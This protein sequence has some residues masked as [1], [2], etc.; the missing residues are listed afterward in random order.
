MSHPR[1][2]FHSMFAIM[3]MSVFLVSCGGGVETSRQYCP[4]QGVLADTE[5]LVGL[6]GDVIW[7]AQISGTVLECHWDAQD[8]RLVTGL[9]MNGNVTSTSEADFAT[10]LTLPA[11]VI[12]T[13]PSD[14]ILVKKEF[15]VEISTS[16]ELQ[17]VS[18]SKDVGSLTLTLAADDQ[19]E[20]H[21]I[22]VGF[23]LTPD[24]LRANRNYRTR[25]LG[26]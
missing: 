22:L 7:S 20:G 9:T 12:M 5:R 13:G 6:S 23:R 11:F 16:K 4:T 8:R 17:T 21:A 10:K 2:S 19:I 18:F 26:L 3:L 1:R 15:D 14:T 24:Q 25:K